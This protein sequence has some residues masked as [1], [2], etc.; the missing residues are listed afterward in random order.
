EQRDAPSAS[1]ADDPSIQRTRY[2]RVIKPTQSLLNNFEAYGRDA[3]AYALNQLQSLHEEFAHLCLVPSYLI[4]ELA[5]VSVDECIEQEP[6]QYK[7][8]IRSRFAEEWKRAMREEHESLTRQK[9]F[10]LVE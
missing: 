10:S 9:V 8:A 2:G 5:C 3:Q 6:N 1:S 4:D 7:D